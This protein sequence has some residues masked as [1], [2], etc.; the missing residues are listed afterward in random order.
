[1]HFKKMAG[2]KFPM[3]YVYHAILIK[4]MNINMLYNEKKKEEKF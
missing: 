3:L 1:M 4:H 2:T